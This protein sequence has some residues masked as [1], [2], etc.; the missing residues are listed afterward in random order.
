MA[1]EMTKNQ[2]M[3][4]GG[5][6]AT[7]AIGLVAWLLYYM[8]SA[9]KLDEG[10]YVPSDDDKCGQ[11]LQKLRDV[12]TNCS[13]DECGVITGYEDLCDEAGFD[14]WYDN[15]DLM[16]GQKSASAGLVMSKL[17]DG[18]Y[19]F[20]TATVDFMVKYDIEITDSDTFT[21]SLS[22]TNK[23]GAETQDIE[24]SIDYKRSS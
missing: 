12:F 16:L 17:H 14:V 1:L 23:K 2:K 7:V 15:G 24:A 21:M 20:R 22:V 19:G 3:I 13:S 10:K 4:A 5:I 8:F 9:K 6:I 18:T 11:T